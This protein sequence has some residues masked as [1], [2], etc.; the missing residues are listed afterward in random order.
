MLL[1]ILQNLEQ[2]KPTVFLK[3]K[4]EVLALSCKLL[5]KFQKCF[6]HITEGYFCENYQAVFIYW[7]KMTEV[8]LTFH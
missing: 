8:N 1:K 6:F 4:A 7:L 3:N 5:K 2:E